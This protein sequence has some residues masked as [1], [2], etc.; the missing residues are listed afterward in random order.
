M[1]ALDLSEHQWSE[2]YH[3]APAELDTLRGVVQ[4][5]AVEPAPTLEGTYRL[6]PGSTVGAFETA[7]LSV[8]IQPKI[9]I[10]RLL[11]LVCYA[12]AKF[13]PRPDLFDYPQNYGLP[14]V[15]AL[16]FVSAAR[17]AFGN[18]LLHGYRTEEDSLH[19][20][21]GRI[22]FDDQIRHQLGIAP[23]IEVRYSEFTDDILVNRLVKAATYRLARMRLQFAPARR[24][25]GW[26]AD[27]LNNVTL[28]EFAPCAL[29]EINFDRLNEHY[30]EV[31]SLSRLI[32][33]RST[34]ELERADVR[35]SGFLV[36]MD[37]VFQ[38]FVTEALRQK[39]KLPPHRFLEKN[40]ESLD[41]GDRISLRPDL[42]WWEETDC[43]FVGD[44]KYKN[45]SERSVPTGDIYQI[46]AYATALDLPGG[47]LIY[48][49]DEAN[50]GTYCTRHSRKRLEVAALD[51][52]G[53]LDVTLNRISDVAAVANKLRNKARSNRRTR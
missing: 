13:K 49:Q 21:R 8:T 22:R 27:S 7:T 42:T 45:I 5:L 23:P 24:Q 44:A 36:D 6:R 40:I 41:D 30:G 34:F 12:M 20:V 1:R 11:S 50:A 51:L 9:S 48:A 14:D 31:V 52:S 38:E 47:L 29:P 32:L 46:L 18:G 37:E 10:P 43:V 25:L 33:R 16:A 26:V 3:L 2:P 17:R 4:P 35:A 15:L 39:L 28:L 53:T 19:S